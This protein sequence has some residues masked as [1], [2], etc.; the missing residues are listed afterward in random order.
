MSRAGLTPDRVVEAASNL[1]DGHGLEG[2]TLASVAEHLGVRTPS[3]YSHVGGLEDL[4][5]SVGL[6]ALGE[7][8]EACRAEIGRASCRERV[9]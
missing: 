5:R 1:I 3:L 4:R 8:D 6:R 7:L 9:L 2:V